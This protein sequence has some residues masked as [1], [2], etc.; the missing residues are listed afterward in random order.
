[1]VLASIYRGPHVADI[2]QKRLID[3]KALVERRNEMIMR[4]PGQFN[5][6]VADHVL[7]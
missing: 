3:G 2:Q 4:C 5:F 1:M 7:R 6:S